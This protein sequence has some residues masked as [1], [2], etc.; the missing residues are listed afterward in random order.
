MLASRCFLAGQPRLAADV[1]SSPSRLKTAPTI[2]I[3][4][5]GTSLKKFLFRLDRPFFWSVAG[6]KPDTC[7]RSRLKRSVSGETN[8]CL[9]RWCSRLPLTCP[10]GPGILRQNNNG[11]TRDFRISHQA[12]PSATTRQVAQW[13]L[14][15]NEFY[16]YLIFS[17]LKKVEVVR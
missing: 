12:S 4:F 6:L 2:H 5:Y 13:L 3:T 11:K 10:K 17:H 14:N 16:K 9:D 7:L 15:W 1:K 8:N